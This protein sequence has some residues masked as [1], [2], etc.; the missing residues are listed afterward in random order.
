MSFRCEHCQKSFDT[1]WRINEQIKRKIPIPRFCSKRC[2]HIRVMPD[3]AKAKIRNSLK[4]HFTRAGKLPKVCKY[5]GQEKCLRKDVC[6]RFRSF[7]SLI[8]YY[9]FDASKIGTIS[10]YEEFDRVVNLLKEEYYSN[11]LSTVAIAEKYGY[12]NKFNLNKLL[13]SLFEIRTHSDA[14][15][16]AVIEERLNMAVPRKNQY[17]CGHH[18]TWN[19]KRIFYRSS[20]ELEYAMQLD[21]QRIDYN[22]ESLRIL[23]WD[24]QRCIQRVAVPDFYLIADNT[25]VEIKGSYMYNEQN[26]KDKKKAYIEHGFKFKLLLDKQ[27]VDTS[28]W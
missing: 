1:D 20:Y 26:M 6:Q 19:S 16:N 21:K 7:D 12:L 15:R 4:Q 11:K 5:C 8:K 17:K 13:R 24:S 9:G 10:V 2:A 25:I 23:Y 28:S 22:V 27:E 3:E 18:V 14:A